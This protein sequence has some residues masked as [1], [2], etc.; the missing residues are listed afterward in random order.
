MEAL[1]LMFNSQP[2]MAESYACVQARHIAKE[3]RKQ[4]VRL[5][6][7]HQYLAIAAGKEPRLLVES[8]WC[9]SYGFYKLMYFC[10][11][12]EFRHGLTLKIGRLSV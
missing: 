8:R 11:V 2:K 5:L 4:G 12:R 3:Q 1:A 10:T 6:A 7:V 9:K